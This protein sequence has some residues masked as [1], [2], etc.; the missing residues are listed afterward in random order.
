MK[1]QTIA[2]VSYNWVGN[3]EFDFGEVAPV[4]CSPERLMDEVDQEIIELA[5]HLSVLS[6]RT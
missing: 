3:H 4:P 2:K 6:I 5:I 1:P